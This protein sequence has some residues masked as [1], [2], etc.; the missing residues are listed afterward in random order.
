[1]EFSI[2]LF[3]PTVSAG[4]NGEVTILRG[5]GNGTFQN[6][7]T[8]LLPG[9]AGEILTGYFD[10][11]QHSDLA[12]GFYNYSPHVTTFLGDGQ[13]SFVPGGAVSVGDAH[14]IAAADFDGDGRLDLAVATYFPQSVVVAL[15]DGTGHFGRKH[16]YVLPARAPFPIDVAAGDFNDDGRPDLATANYGTDDSVILLNLPK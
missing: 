4:G 6:T 10:G 5:N 15:G 8:Y 11:D 1:M 7:Y 12:V 14:G 13:G 2:W 16:K 9:N 3:R